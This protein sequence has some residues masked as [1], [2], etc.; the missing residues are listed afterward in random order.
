MQSAQSCTLTGCKSGF[1]PVGQACD[2]DSNTSC[3]PASSPVDCTQH[4]SNGSGVCTVPSSGAVPVCALSGCNSGYHRDATDSSCVQNTDTACGDPPVDCKTIDPNGSSTC[5]VANG[6][7]TGPC[8]PVAC[9]NGYNYDTLVSPNKCVAAQNCCGNSCANCD[10]AVAN[11]SAGCSGSTQS[12]QS[13]TLTGCKTGYA[14]VGQVCDPDSNTSCGAAASPVDC[15]KQYA[16]GSGVCNAPGGVVPFC[17]LSTC[18]PGFH[19]DATKSTCVQ[20]TDAACGYPTVDCQT[21]D[22]NGTSTCTVTNGVVTGPCTQV[23]CN[24]PN[25]NYDT[26]TSTCVAIQNCCGSS[27]VNCAAFANGTASCT[28][29]TQS[30]QSCTVLTCSV[31]YHA[32]STNSSCQLNTDTACGSPPVNCDSS[33]NTSGTCNVNAGT[34]SANSCISGDHVC[35]TPGQCVSNFSTATCGAACNPCSAPA[36]GT[37]TCDGTSCGFTCFGGYHASGFSCVQD[38]ATCCGTSCNNCTTT[39]NA[40]GVCAQPSE[41]CSYSCNSNY[42]FCGTICDSNYSLN[43]CGASC[44]PC[45]GDANG[46]ATC[47]GTSC[48][49]VCNAGYN[50]CGGGACVA[51]TNTAC[52]GTC[53]DC[54]ANANCNNRC[55]AA[56][57]V[58]VSICG[59][60]KCCG[61]GTCSVNGICQ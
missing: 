16:N 6:I 39:A 60:Q 53:T 33:P 2:P 4:Y 49:I 52:G 28:G 50:N 44:T 26:A 23:V 35:G 11:G 7:A 45:P 12:S 5:A 42:H 17:S 25:Y 19:P 61:P 8:T 38:T 36:N 24:A 37:A 3:G 9:Y 31:G 1:S 56:L 32:D 29:A 18:N 57:G 43:S 13:C 51:E 15:T 55:D 40:T 46:T 54:T 47:D 41:T 30:A 14:P 21:I 58:C 34:C 20:N 22:P 59:S 27:C 10:T 48:H